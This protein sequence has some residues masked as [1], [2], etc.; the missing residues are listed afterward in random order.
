MK[1]P[2]WVQKEFN[3]FD[4]DKN[5]IITQKEIDNHK[6]TDS[7]FANKKGFKVENGMDINLFLKE[8]RSIYGTA[9]QFTDNDYSEG[10]KILKKEQF[11]PTDKTRK[12]TEDDSKSVQVEQGEFAIKKYS[13]DTPSLQT[14][15]VWNCVAVTIYDKKTKTGFMAHIDT[16]D[17][18]D[19]LEKVLKNS[20]F[21]PE[22]S[23]VRIIGGLTNLSEGTIEIVDETI[24]K[25]NLKVVEYDILGEG[26]RDIQLDLKTG[27]VF[28]Y[29]ELHRKYKVAHDKNINKLYLMPNERSDEKVT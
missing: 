26:R 19:S 8:N 21:N 28:D 4:K 12:F 24:K 9:V 3:S 18:A 22:T 27:E 2:E 11:R 15:N 14:Y 16:V 23:E 25:Y 29:K 1:I 6:S 10:R 20:N 5:G 7:I 13:K 17:R